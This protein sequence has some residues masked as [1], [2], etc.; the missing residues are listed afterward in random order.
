MTV[1]RYAGTPADL[2]V[3][4]YFFCRFGRLRCDTLSFDATGSKF[5]VLFAISENNSS[6]NLL[7]PVALLIRISLLV[8]IV[9]KNATDSI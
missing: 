2:L 8:A 6:K 7:P 1:D 3:V 4:G 9:A 5:F